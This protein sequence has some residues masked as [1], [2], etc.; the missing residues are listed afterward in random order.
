MRE[1]F[2][3]NEFLTLMQD[4]EAEFILEHAEK[5]LK[6]LGDT[7]TQISTRT[8]GLITLS[9]GS[10]I[11]LIGY[12]MNTLTK[13]INNPSGMTALMTSAYLFYWT[14]R[15]AKNIEPTLYHSIG[16][17]PK[18]FFRNDVFLAGNEKWR[19]RMIKANEIQEYQF[20][21]EETMT[22]NTVRWGKFTK[23]LTKLKWTP[24][25]MI[26]FYALCLIILYLCRS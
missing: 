6:D 1:N 10:M 13:S 20:R 21:I 7:A 23:C 25:I 12:G 22:T 16:A 26:A 9:T 24:V 17:R 3:T 18:D 4:E 15:L 5:L 14:F 19:L 11:A 2:I 8:T